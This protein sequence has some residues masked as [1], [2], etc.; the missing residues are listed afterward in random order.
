[1]QSSSIIRVSAP[2]LEGERL[3]YRLKNGSNLEELTLWFERP[4]LSLSSIPQSMDGIA[5]AVIFYAMRCGQPLQLEGKIGAATLRN[6]TEL[7]RAWSVWKPSCYQ[8][9]PIYHDG[10]EETRTRPKESAISAFSGGVDA[11]FNLVHNSE[12][13]VPLRYPIS[14]AL[15]VHGFDIPLAKEAAFERVAADYKEILKTFGVELITIRTNLK[16]ISFTDWE[17][18]F[19]ALLTACFYHSGPDF[20]YALVGSSEAYDELVIPWGSSPISDHLFSSAQLEIV[21]YGAAFTRS[22][23]VR[24]LSNNSAARQNLRVCWRSE[25]P[26][27]NCGICEKCTRTRL[28]FALA[29]HPNLKVLGDG[30]LETL[31][32]NL[33]IRNAAVA[34]E[35][36]SILRAADAR[37]VKERWVSLLRSRMQ[38]WQMPTQGHRLVQGIRAL[39]RS[40]RRNETI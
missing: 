29:G 23:K 31:I 7:Q 24:V 15:L 3:I 11:F 13:P 2:V 8:V 21:H 18:T 12:Q 14:H 32:A 30:A 35:L 26:T 6:L 9:V 38:D 40:L 33:D 16:E 1:M 4:G 22:E 25:D 19:I 34:N 39:V 10:V 17:D 5:A 28:N 36:F 27:R 20:R 37:N